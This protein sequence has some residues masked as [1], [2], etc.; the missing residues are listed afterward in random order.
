[1]RA[2][3]KQ[4]EAVNIASAKEEVAAWEEM[5][6]RLQKLSP[7]HAKRKTLE[8]EEVPALAAKVKELEKQIP[9]FRLKAD[10]GCLLN[11][12]TIIVI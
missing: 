7:A 5:F 11:I 8:S 3:I 4:N 2:L 1:L 10:E 12:L 6:E 9:E